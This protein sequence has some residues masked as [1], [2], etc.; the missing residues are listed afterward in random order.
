MPAPVSPTPSSRAIVTKGTSVSSSATGTR[1]GC[2]TSHSTALQDFIA[3]LDDLPK[4]NSPL[5][6]SGMFFGLM[7][8]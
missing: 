6:K 7:G 1:K 5:A 4:A 3:E 8:A 2:S